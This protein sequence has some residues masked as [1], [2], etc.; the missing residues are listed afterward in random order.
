MQMTSSF[1]S[2][3]QVRN[4]R[5]WVVPL[6]LA[7]GQM[8][9][10][11]ASVFAPSQT[12]ILHPATALGLRIDFNYNF[13]NALPPLLRNSTDSELRLN[14]D[15]TRD[16]VHGSVATYRRFYLFA[17]RSPLYRDRLARAFRVT[18]LAPESI[19]RPESPD[20]PPQLAPETPAAASCPQ[21]FEP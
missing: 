11:L 12:I 2:Q 21:P 3:Q 6:S 20:A 16:F 7:L 10:A 15:H 13:Q 5:Y 14:T 19:A 9:W 8:A 1:A 18:R 4:K 17:L